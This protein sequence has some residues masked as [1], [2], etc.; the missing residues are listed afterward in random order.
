MLDLA[1]DVRNNSRL[2][3]QIMMTEALD[4]LAFHVGLIELLSYWK[5]ACAPEIVIK[6]GAQSI[7]DAITMPEWTERYAYGGG[8]SYELK[9]GGKYHHG[10]SAD[11]GALAARASSGAEIGPRID[12]S[13]GD[14]ATAMTL[15]GGIMMARLLPSLLIGPVA[16]GG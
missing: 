9:A 16:R 1:F 2:G 7:W 6:A 15:F 14:H 11:M 3:C 10:A 5:T 4:G 8:V 13:V 12:R